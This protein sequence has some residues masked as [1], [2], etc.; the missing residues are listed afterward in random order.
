MI[1]ICILDDDPMSSNILQ[2]TLTEYLSTHKISF[3]IDQYEN[4]ENYI[5]ICIDGQVVSV[6]SVLERI[7]SSQCHI[8]GGF[9]YISARNLSAQIKSGAL[10]FDLKVIEVK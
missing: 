3:E 4:G 1:R 6:P 2:Q 7:D 8:T 5:S 10:P 9:D